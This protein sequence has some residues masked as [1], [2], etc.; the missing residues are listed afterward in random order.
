MA[1]ESSGKRMTEE[2]YSRCLQIAISYVAEHGCIRNRQIRE[3]A[4]ISYDEAI[5]FFNRAI[6]ERHFDRRGKASGTHYVKGES[7]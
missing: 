7:Q 3:V 4:G 5:H 1:S 6:F 2:A